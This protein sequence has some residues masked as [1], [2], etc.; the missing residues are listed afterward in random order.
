MFQRIIV[1]LDGSE[2]ARQALPVAARIARNSGG[3]LLLFSVLH[4]P[5][6][7]TWQMET[8]L[9][10]EDGRRALRKEWETELA[11]LACSEDLKGIE[12]TTEV[13]EDL[14]A[15]AI[16]EK[17]QASQANLIVMCS[18]GRSGITRWAL[19]SVAQKVSR[20][21]PVPVLI[22]HA[23]WPM[24]LPPRGIR[25]L[26]VLVALDG[27]SL[28]E[29]AL[30]PAA[31][32]SELLSA[33]L[34]GALRLV[35][36]LP[37]SSDFDYGQDDAF[38]RAGRQARQEA[39]T[40]LQGIQ[41]RIAS[42]ANVHVAC[43]IASSLD[44]AETLISIAERGEG[45]GLSGITESSD[46]IALTT[47]GRSGLARW[48]MGSIPERILGATRLPLLII[49]PQQTSIHPTLSESTAQ[50]ASQGTD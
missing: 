50:A 7:L 48:V 22:L 49:R 28:A 18:H 3:S 23:G 44:T 30:L 6:N 13:V 42:Q 5:V 43:S 40:Y 32:L 36:S 14:P 16:L 31:R 26:R 47:H 10:Q 41:Q 15:R 19:G 24:T 35:R 39:Q 17:A 1:P 33:P 45:S 12:V 8:G 25:P 9:I 34:P 4:L 46:M 27:S 29:N 21:S 37:F 11:A 20:H 2:R 38:A